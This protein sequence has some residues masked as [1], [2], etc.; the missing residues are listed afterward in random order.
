MKE[1]WR[2]L[3]NDIR[4]IVQEAVNSQDF[5]RLNQNIR[6]TINDA[7]DS[8]AEGFWKSS[9]RTEYGQTG[10]RQGRET[11]HDRKRKPFYGNQR[12]FAGHETAVTRAGGMALS[13]CGGFLGIGTGIALAVLGV[14]TL[15]IGHLLGFTIAGGI[16]IPL[17]GTGVV[18]SC[19]G[20]GKC[21]L[22][23]RFRSYVAGLEGRTYCDI[24]E[25]SRIVGKS[26][27]FVV[28]DLRR[29]IERGWFRQGH[30]DDG[31]TCFIADDATYAQY[32]ATMRQAEALEADK[33]RREEQAKWTEAANQAENMEK[34]GI[35]PEASEVIQA[36]RA[37]VEKIRAC[38]DAIPG[39]EISEKISRIE[40]ITA[41]IFERVERHPE[42]VDDIGKMM[43]YYLPT[44]VKLLE[45]Y[46][47]LSAQP[48]QGENIKS[49]RKEIEDTLDTLTEAFEKLFDSMFQDT[50][51]DVSTDIS[52][53]KTLLAQEGLSEDGLKKK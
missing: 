37:Y 3:G 33:E 27:S 48:V 7:V 36:G 35:S 53:L 4:S 29:M 1:D 42:N 18:M 15:S 11:G 30:L 39:E 28:K 44:T 5:R 26:R 38:N 23:K 10:Y 46:A 12:L 16:L 22:V 31:E 21:S 8:V 47:E 41:R 24:R 51:W 52:V 25:L 19:I 49:S 17:F 9:T 43:E 20:S 32:R 14:L 2:E 45:A 34:A 6:N 13:I 50:A 40:L